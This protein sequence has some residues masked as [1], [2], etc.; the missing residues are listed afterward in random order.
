MPGADLA[1]LRV[2][3]DLQRYVIGTSAGGGFIGIDEPIG[4][5]PTR[6]LFRCF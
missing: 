1:E 5:I 2:L 3:G 4:P 6:S